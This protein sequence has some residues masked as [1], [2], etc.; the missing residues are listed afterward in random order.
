M[1]SRCG[2]LEKHHLK[3]SQLYMSALQKTLPKALCSRLNVARGLASGPPS[4]W[5]SPSYDVS[6]LSQFMS[7]LCWDKHFSEGFLHALTGLSPKPASAAAGQ[8]SSLVTRLDSR[9]GPAILPAPTPIPNAHT[10]HSP[11][12]KFLTSEWQR[13][14]WFHLLN[15]FV[16][17][18]DVRISTETCVLIPPGLSPAMGSHSMQVQPPRS[19]SLFN[20]SINGGEVLVTPISQRY[21]ENIREKCFESALEVKGG[22]ADQ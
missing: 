20:W 9:T 21:P 22:T 17:W 13:A 11:D 3:D 16:P 19:L 5:P 6:C 14:V 12:R 1:S 4:G 10:I 15:S 7:V 2:P 18:K 8:M